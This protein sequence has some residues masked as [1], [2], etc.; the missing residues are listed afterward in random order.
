MRQR[1]SILIGLLWCMVLL[2]LVVIG[3]LHTATMDLKVVRNFSDGI[4]AHYLAVAGA[5][6]A[7]ALLYQNMRDRSHSGIHH[8]AQYYNAADQFKEIHLG[9]GTFSV[10]RRG[11]DD[12][13]GGIIYGVSDEESRLNINT[14]S[15]QVLS[16]LQ[17]INPDTV[18]AI[19]E[20]RGR[21][22]DSAQQRGDPA[23]Y[24]L[25]LQPPYTPRNAP[26]QTVR[27][28]LMVRGV[29]SSL[30]FGNDT[31]A[32]GGIPAV[33]DGIGDAS[34]PSSDNTQSDTGWAGLFTT[35]SSVKD[36]DA[37]G[38]DRINIKSADENTLAGIQGI[39]PTIAHAIVAYRGQN[40]FKSI[41][42]L[43]DV[44]AP[45]DQQGAQAVNTRGRRNS[46][47][48]AGNASGGAKL[49]SNE[50]LM[51]IADSLTVNESGQNQA[52]TININSASLEVLTA[53]PGMNRD[54]AQTVINYRKSSGYLPNIAHLLKVPGFTPDLFKQLAPMISVRS[55]TYRI[56][57]EGKIASSGVRRRIQEIVQI[58]LNQV[59]TRSYREDDL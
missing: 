30:L 1:A 18:Q 6:K 42:D 24:Y 37:S 49:I 45:Q 36:I 34:N 27:E 59:T 51:D 50:L 56:L 40:D 39:T 31:H 5:E 10:L 55:E 32:N 13:G 47:N 12:E 41:A 28:L 46:G 4:Q 7:K 58:Q 16:R 53:M 57:S 9:R 29:T 25:S 33:G 2:S 20:W 21:S 43:L 54:L 48:N 23:E 19:L 26:Y 35:D 15:D 22:E 3:V 14:V 44:T 8:T 52:G 11:T 38:Q 17:G